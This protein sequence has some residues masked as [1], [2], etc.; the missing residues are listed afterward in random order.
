MDDADREE[1]PGPPLPPPLSGRSDK[2]AETREIAV[3]NH[4][5]GRNEGRARARDDSRVRL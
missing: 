5:E 1:A 3:R 2:G 4:E